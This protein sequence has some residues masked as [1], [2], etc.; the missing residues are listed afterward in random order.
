MLA[1]MIAFEF[2]GTPT[3]TILPAKI[4]RGRLFGMTGFLGVVRVIQNRRN[5]L[6]KQSFD[7]S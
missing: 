1:A 2:A 7:L 6:A 4:L 5:G 3:A